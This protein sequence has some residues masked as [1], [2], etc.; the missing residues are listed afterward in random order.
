MSWSSLGRIRQARAVHQAKSPTP[1][2]GDSKDAPSTE[3]GEQDDAMQQFLD[4]V[5]DF[6][7]A[8]REFHEK[9]FEINIYVSDSGTTATG[10]ITRN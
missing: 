2:A 7:D 3:Q 5:A 1:A 10:R 4:G 9:S 8:V 6:A